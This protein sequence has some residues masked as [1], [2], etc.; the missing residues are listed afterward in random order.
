MAKEMMITSPMLIRATYRRIRLVQHLMGFR[1]LLPL[2]D[3][4]SPFGEDDHPDSE[5]KA[6][7]KRDALEAVMQETRDLL[8]E[9]RDAYDDVGDESGVMVDSEE[10]LLQ[11]QEYGSSSGH[12]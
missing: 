10:T 3:D 5:V 11:L 8:D 12:S 2:S 7:T 1:D 4:G 9:F 6:W